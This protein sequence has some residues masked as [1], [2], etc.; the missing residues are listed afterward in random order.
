MLPK[1]Y[2][3]ETDVQ[4]GTFVQ[5]QAR[6][7]KEDN[8]VYV[9][10]VQ[11]IADLPHRW[12]VVDR[13]E[14]GLNERVVYFRSAKGWFRR[15]RQANRYRRAQQM[16]YAQWGIDVDVCHVHVP[17]RSA[18]LA[19]WLYI[20]KRVPFV[21]TEHWSG[22]L[23]G[24]FHQKNSLDKFLY[25]GVVKKAAGIVVVSELLRQKFK[26]N[27][28]LDALVIPNL[29][30][31]PLTVPDRPSAADDERIRLLSVADMVDHIKDITG[32]IAAFEQ[33]RI[34]R[35]Q[36]H[37]TLI[38]GGAD[39][40]H[41]RAVIRRR[42]LENSIEMR[43]RLPHAEVLQ[44][45]SDCAIYVCNSTVET[46]GMAVAEALMAGKPV[47]CTRCGGPEEFLSAENALQV[48]PGNV[49]QLTAALLDMAQHYPT[50]DAQQ[51]STAIQGRF[52]AAA[53]RRQLNALY[54]A[55]VQLNVKKNAPGH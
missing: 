1:W 24:L 41:I 51:I 42:K 2:P 4:L 44:A 10:Y 38:G 12:K 43:G 31:G 23:T 17:Y 28:G 45:Y 7:L 55:V 33:A 36:L 49:P 39:E 27:T 26:A 40:Q 6:L 16:A 19:L 47:V 14:E 21:V 3:N 11:A 22:H 5:Q 35:P 20:K 18:L 52:G 34:V 13:T 37:L 30:E 54:H 46:F 29:I 32:L 48:D 50:Y 15:W 9:I 8:D 25:K 53:V